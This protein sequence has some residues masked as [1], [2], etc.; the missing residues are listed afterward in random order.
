MCIL[1]FS[2]LFSPL[3]SVN[4]LSH[5]SICCEHI[6]KKTITCHFFPWFSTK[7]LF[8]RQNDPPD[9]CCWFQYKF[10][11]SHSSHISKF[12]YFVCR[13]NCDNSD[14]PAA[15]WI[16]LMNLEM[17]K[18]SD[19]FFSAKC[20]LETKKEKLRKSDLR[21]F[22]FILL[23]ISACRYWCSVIIVRYDN[24]CSGTACMYYLTAADIQSHMA[25]SAVTV[26]DQVS[27]LEAVK[28][29]G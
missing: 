27:C 8:S 22:I 6:S 20:L 13:L 29:Y 14:Q 12:F 9:I 15:Q 26:E 25:D 3:L 2:I 5:C 18:A 24:S 23:P 28:A 10:Q 16:F 4:S 21:S 7:P 1:S 17:K 19:R 11:Q